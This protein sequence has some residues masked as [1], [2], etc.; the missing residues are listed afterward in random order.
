MRLKSILILNSFFH[1]QACPQQNDHH[2]PLCVEII[3]KHVILGLS[4]VSESFTKSIPNE[5]GDQ[6]V[7][8]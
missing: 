2:N 3:T 6:T 1:P 7:V 5:T 8:C 4:G